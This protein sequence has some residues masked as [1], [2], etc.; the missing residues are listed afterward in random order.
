MSE[1]MPKH[2]EDATGIDRREVLKGGTALAALGAVGGWFG[3]STPAAAEEAPRPNIV[4]IVSD[5]QGWHDVGFNGSPEIKTPNLDKLAGTGAVFDQFYALPMCTPSR[6]TLMTGRYPFRYGLQTAVIPSGG[7]YGL[8]L[9]EYTLPQMLKDAGYRTAMV[10]KWHLGH[11]RREFWPKQRGFES[12]YGPLVG[13]IDHFKHA[14]HGVTDWYRDNTLL[15]EEGYDTDL[16]GA[17]AV[18]VIRGHDKQKPLFLYLAFTAPHTP[19]QAPKAWLDKYAGIADERKR[20]YAAQISCMDEAIGKVVAALDESGLRSNTLIVFHSDNGGTRSAMFAGDSGIT[21]ALP[22]DNGIY[23]DGKGT[24]YE[25]GT[26]VC[27]LANWPGKIATGHVKGL[28]HIADMYPTLAALAG[29]K[30]D[31]SKALD[32]LNVWNAIAKGAA[33]PR[34][35]IVYNVE[36]YRVA[37]RQG[38]MKLLWVPILPGKLELYD[39]AKDP[40]EKTNLADKNRRLVAKLQSRAEDLAKQAVPPLV[41]AEMVR[42]TFS[43]PPS[44]PKGDDPAPAGAKSAPSQGFVS[45]IENADD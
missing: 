2:N 7:S 24:L 9:D 5:D 29:A 31:K 28:V 37:V 27:G 15:E 3:A 10:G 36:P 26:R 41:M 20:A 21:G 40:S 6:A 11:A 35:E 19:Y 43:A 34:T 38:D 16:F 17:E 12:Y 42:M 32:G 22:P 33:S 45:D 39:L 4:Y 18:N 8:A 23:R 14:S 13:E 1:R 44:T 25:G 30:T